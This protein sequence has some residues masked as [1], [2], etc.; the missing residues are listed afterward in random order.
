MHHFRRCSARIGSLISAANPSEI[1]TIQASAF[2]SGRQIA[3]KWRKPED[4]GQSMILVQDGCE[5]NEL[6]VIVRKVR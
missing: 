3:S 4:L 1:R 2:Y 5:I 6:P